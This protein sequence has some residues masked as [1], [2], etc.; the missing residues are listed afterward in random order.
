MPCDQDGIAEI[1]VY[2]KKDGK[3][4]KRK[5]AGDLWFGVFAPGGGIL[6]DGAGKPL[7]SVTDNIASIAYGTNCKQ[8]YD[9][10]SPDVPNGKIDVLDAVRAGST[11]MV[12]RF[13]RAQ[14]DYAPISGDTTVDFPALPAG[15]RWWLYFGYSGG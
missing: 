2:I 13:I 6:K 11:T 15:R 12:F 8:S 3:A 9:R 7:V 1:K 14:T 10:L 5:Y 4:G